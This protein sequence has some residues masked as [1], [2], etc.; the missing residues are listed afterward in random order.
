MWFMGRI[1]QLC[2]GAI[3]M[4]KYTKYKAT[5]TPVL[6]SVTWVTHKIAGEVISYHV[7][8]TT[9][10]TSY[11]FKALDADGLLI[12]ESTN[13]MTG[14]MAESSNHEIVNDVLTLSLTGCSANEPFTIIIRVLL[15]GGQR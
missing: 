9:A 2:N 12:Y 5:V 7:K 13:P 1:R 4:L 6:G 8:P 11:Y 14:E 3:I 15:D 10:S